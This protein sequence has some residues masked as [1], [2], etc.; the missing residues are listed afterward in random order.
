MAVKTA[1]HSRLIFRRLHN[2]RKVGFVLLLKG[3]TKDSNKKRYLAPTPPIPREKNPSSLLDLQSSNKKR[4][5]DSFQDQ[6]ESVKTIQRP[7]SKA[8]NNRP[9]EQ[10]CIFE[11]GENA[12]RNPTNNLVSYE[13]GNEGDIQEVISRSNSNQQSVL[14]RM[15]HNSLS[16]KPITTQEEKTTGVQMTTD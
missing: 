1:Q 2:Y 13:S 5:A 11:F 7:R 4:V 12:A 14:S 3:K 9:S 8:S 10:Q 6:D 16:T 15:D